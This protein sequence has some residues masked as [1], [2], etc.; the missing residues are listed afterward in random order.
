MSLLTSEN[1]LPPVFRLADSD[2]VWAV[3][4]PSS[5]SLAAY[6]FLLFPDLG[7]PAIVSLKIS[8]TTHTAVCLIS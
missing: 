3:L 8:L 7:H 5:F 2:L 6:T 4:T 1:R